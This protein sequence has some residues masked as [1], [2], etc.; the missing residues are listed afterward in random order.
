MGGVRSIRYHY[1]SSSLCHVYLHHSRTA[2]VLEDK[3]YGRSGFR[4]PSSVGAHWDRFEPKTDV[5]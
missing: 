4:A 2:N 1:G 5:L 3:V